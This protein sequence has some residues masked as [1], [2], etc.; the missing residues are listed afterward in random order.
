[1][2]GK[3]LRIAETVNRCRILS[4]LEKCPAWPAHRLGCVCLL[5]KCPFLCQRIQIR[6]D[7]QLLSVAPQRIIP[8]LICKIKYNIWFSHPFL[9]L[10]Q[11]RSD[12]S[13]YKIFLR[14]EEQQNHRHH[15]QYRSCHHLPPLYIAVCFKHC[16]CK[17]H[18][19][20]IL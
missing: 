7:I 12:D 19:F 8:L 6:T 20:H 18:C 10:L 2:Q 15:Y 13:L 1:M 16:E 14:T 4:C 9:L 3:R 17:L 11:P 5:K